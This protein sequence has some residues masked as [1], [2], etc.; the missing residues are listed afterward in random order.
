VDRYT[1]TKR[2]VERLD[3]I[4]TLLVTKPKLNVCAVMAEVRSDSIQLYNLADVGGTHELAL[5]HLQ[6]T[7]NSGKKQ[8]QDQIPLPRRLPEPQLKGDWLKTYIRQYVYTA[9]NSDQAVLTKSSGPLSD[10]ENVSI[11]QSLFRNFV[12]AVD[13]KRDAM[14]E[15]KRFVYLQCKQKIL[16]HM[17][18]TIHAESTVCFFSL[19][20]VN[21]I[22]ERQ[23]IIN[24][25][26][27]AWGD[28]HP[29]FQHRSEKALQSA[30]KKETGMEFELDANSHFMLDEES[31][32][33]FHWLIGKLFDLLQYLLDSLPERTEKKQSKAELNA[34]YTDAQGKLSR[35]A[36]LMDILA[37]LVFR[38]LTFQRHMRHIAIG[39]WIMGN[40]CDSTAKPLIRVLSFSKEERS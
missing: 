32:V 17:Q 12:S 33:R 28:I 34:A 9:L 1:A 22:L 14:M 31:T 26:E 7:K 39:G 27:V 11:L 4:A 19:F 13:G 16:Q 15:I 37:D 25:S 24:F 38:S 18:V 21:R 29:L 5:K 10:A 23:L 3:H 8:S 35:I 36:R 40:A 30:V 6:P 2:K 20:E